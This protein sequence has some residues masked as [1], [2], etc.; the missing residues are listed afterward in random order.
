MRFIVTPDM[1][2]TK[3]DEH[4]NISDINGQSLKD[5]VASWIQRKLP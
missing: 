3:K 4:H 5:N 2:H 1:T